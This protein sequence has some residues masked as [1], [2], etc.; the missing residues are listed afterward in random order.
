MIRAGC[1]PVTLLAC[2]VLVGAGGCGGTNSNYVTPDPNDSS[3]PVIGLDV[4]NLPLQQGASSQPNPESVD[5][6]CCDVTRTAD[7]TELTLVAGITDDESG[8]RE[9]GIWVDMSTTCTMPGGLARKIGPGL[10]GAPSAEYKDQ[11]VNPT[12]VAK[13]VFTSMSLSRASFTRCAAGETFAGEANVWAEGENFAG[14]KARTKT[15]T[16]RFD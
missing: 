8:G 13:N 9:V 15:F 2:F 5:A 1:S 16:L 7:H 12:S 3:P 11:R 10:L 6:G 14:K 4:Y